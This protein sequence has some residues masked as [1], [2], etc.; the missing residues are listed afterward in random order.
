MEGDTLRF[1][2]CPRRSSAHWCIIDLKTGAHVVTA[3]S[4]LDTLPE[5]AAKLIAAGLNTPA[6]SCRRIN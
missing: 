4:L 6:K 2:A 1:I 3:S 5:Q